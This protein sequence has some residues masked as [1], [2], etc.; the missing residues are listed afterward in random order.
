MS[1]KPQVQTDDT[2]KWYENSLCFATKKEAEESA[3]DLMMRWT[4]V[5]DHRAH[6]SSHPVTHTYI[7][8][9][10]KHVEEADE[11]KKRTD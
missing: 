1:W 2:G 6:E 3:H 5:R 11:T 10:L 8:R 9:Q 7:D 4:S